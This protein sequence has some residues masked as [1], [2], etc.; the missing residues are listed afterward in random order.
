MTHTAVVDDEFGSVQSSADEFDVHGLTMYSLIK[1]G[2]NTSSLLR[3][4]SHGSG[5]GSDELEQSISSSSRQLFQQNIP[6][7]HHANH[8][9]TLQSAS[10]FLN[11]DEHN[12]I[13]LSTLFLLAVAVG[14]AWSAVAAKDKNEAGREKK[15]NDRIGREASQETCDVLVQQHHKY[16]QPRHVYDLISKRL[17]SDDFSIGLVP[18][19]EEEDEDVQEQVEQ[20]EVEIALEKD[21]TTSAA[22]TTATND[23]YDARND[24]STT[25]NADEASVPNATKDTASPHPP[26]DFPEPQWTLRYKGEW[27]PPFH[28]TNN[29]DDESS[30]VLEEVIIL[31][32]P[33]VR[34]NTDV[35]VKNVKKSVSFQSNVIAQHP[36][37]EEEVTVS[38]P[39][40][41]SK[42][43]GLS[44][45]RFS[46]ASLC[47][48]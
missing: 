18:T 48:R 9:S 20:D 34:K 17:A 44:W 29:N 28:P 38:S 21:A 23:A 8:H 46:L 40:A 47:V 11:L 24:A 25:T 5:N 13:R 19:I 43:K 4:Y 7:Q 10:S 42:K 12:L 26:A 36:Q 33:I 3:Y 14:F 30:I 37:Q 22:A 35:N 27:E 15:R 31:T 1:N 41:K 32:K 39:T 45:L 6:P 2:A 16:E